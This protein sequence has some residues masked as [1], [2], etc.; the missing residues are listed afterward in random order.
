MSIPLLRVDNLQVHFRGE[1]GIVPAVR[2]IS[3]TIQP[4]ETVA[5][6]G[7][8]GSGKSV[9][10]LSLLQ[11]LP[12]NAIVQANGLYLRDREIRDLAPEALRHLR[13]EQIAMI[14]QEPMTA[15]NPVQPIFRQL[16]ESF[17]PQGVAAAERGKLRERALELL[18]LTGITD[19]EQKLDAYPH[20]LSGGQR[21]RV[22]IAMALARRPALLIADEPTTALDVTIQAQILELLSRLQ[23][24]LGMAML[25][26]T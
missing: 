24:E 10:A 15:M 6:V 26:I 7:E 9:A 8:S 18:A 16:A 2:G 14:F 20:Q 12:G 13:G 22:M 23:R 25:L 4:G 21:Q 17:A 19:P 3:L 1:A 11:L 5:L